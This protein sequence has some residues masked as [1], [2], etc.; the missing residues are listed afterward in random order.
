MAYVEQNLGNDETIVSKVKF[1]KMAAAGAI[2]LAFIFCCMGIAPNSGYWIVIAVVILVVRILQIKSTELAVTNKRVMGKVGLF[3]TKSLDSP[4]NKVTGVTV[5]KSFLA[6]VFGYGKIV[7]NTAS[8]H[9]DFNYVK[10]PDSFRSAVMEQIS[11]YEEESI[12]RQAVTLAGAIK[13]N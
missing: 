2:I 6:N 12:R 3:R 7:I 1:S 8:T 10:H 5:E 11:A 13:N 4:I 9:H